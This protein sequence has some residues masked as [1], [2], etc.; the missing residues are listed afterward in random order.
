MP[1]V[2]EID[3]FFLSSCYWHHLAVRLYQKEWR[4]RMIYCT[5]AGGL[6]LLV[7]LHIHMFPHSFRGQRLQYGFQHR[8]AA[9]VPAVMGSD[10][11]RQI[12]LESRT[13]SWYHLWEKEQAVVL[14]LRMFLARDLIFVGDKVDTI[15]ALASLIQ[16][17]SKYTKYILHM[18]Q[19]LCGTLV[20]GCSL[21]AP[22][23]QNDLIPFW[24]IDIQLLQEG[25][26]YCYTI[27]SLQDMGT[28]FIGHALSFVN[29]LNQHN[30][31]LAACRHQ[32]QDFA[33]GHWF[34]LV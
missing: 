28:T 7:R 19:T 24:P 33:H 3:S 13:D 1:T 12:M 17:R 11:N 9:M 27:V 10:F 31:V 6:S 25:Y 34:H 30:W 4:G 18:L 15:Y 29:R 20:G 2:E 16:M 22:V 5:M 26:G 32:I 21:S 23:I 8:I 14:L